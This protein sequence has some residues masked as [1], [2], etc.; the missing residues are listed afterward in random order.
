MQFDPEYLEL[1][2]RHIRAAD[3]W[4]SWTNLHAEHFALLEHADFVREA[5]GLAEFFRTTAKWM[6]CMG[7]TGHEHVQAF[8]LALADLHSESPAAE[9]REAAALWGRAEAEVKSARAMAAM[10]M[11]R[12]Q[13]SRPVERGPLQQQLIDAANRAGRELLLAKLYSG[14]S[15]GDV[16]ANS[17]SNP[18]T[19]A[20]SVGDL[21]AI[22]EI[23][24]ET[25]ERLTEQSTRDGDSQRIGESSGSLKPRDKAT[26]NMLMLEMLQ[27]RK[28]ECSGWSIRQWAEAINRAISTIQDT[29]TWKE[30]ELARESIKA[31]KSRD[32]RRRTKPKK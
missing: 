19:G 1:F 25:A 15:S 24:S 14:S 28:A 18:E 3:Q 2:P 9:F 7:D 29:E 26:A 16:A 22:E 32:R 13:A 12:S 4:C 30:L 20:M 6:Q 11:D 27:E 23:S 8:A 17:E 31:E 21:D 10:S 5:H